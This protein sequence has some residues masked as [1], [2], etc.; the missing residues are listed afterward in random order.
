MRQRL[1]Q[2][3]SHKNKKK[4]RPEPVRIPKEIIEELLREEYIRYEPEKRRFE[5][6]GVT[7]IL[8]ETQIPRFDVLWANFLDG[9]LPIPQ[10]CVLRVTEHRTAGLRDVF[11]WRKLLKVLIFDGRGNV[12]FRLPEE[13]LKRAREARRYF[14]L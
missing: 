6:F 8:P 7:D 4:E 10:N 2:G 3:G 9:N 12:Y 1:P 13:I 11:K 14:Q 5:F